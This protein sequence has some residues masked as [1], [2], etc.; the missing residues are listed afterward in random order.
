MQN[1]IQFDSD[2]VLDVHAARFY[3]FDTYKLTTALR[4]ETVNATLNDDSNLPIPISAIPVLKY[5]ASWISP[6]SYQQGSIVISRDGPPQ[7]VPAS[8]LEIK[9]S[10][11]GSARAYAMLLFGI[12]WVLAHCS[13]GIVAL[14][15]TEAGPIVFLY[16]DSLKQLA[17]AVGILLVIPQLRGAMPDAPGF[18]GMWLSRSIALQLGVQ[19]LM[20]L[21]C[22]YSG[23]LIGSRYIFRLVRCS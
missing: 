21:F 23:V 2:H 12:N 13:F 7:V 11:P 20:Y 17:A 3:P 6:S 1:L 19:S 16:E 18:D 10:R 9:I 5:T 8:Q 22:F 15:K 14:G 4:I